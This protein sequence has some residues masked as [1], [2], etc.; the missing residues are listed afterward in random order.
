MPSQPLPGSQH[1]M[2]F[3]KSRAC[4]GW[5]C[6]TS[7]AQAGAES[8][9]AKSQF[10]AL[11]TNSAPSYPVASLCTLLGVLPGQDGETA[12]EGRNRQKWELC[13]AGHLLWILILTL[14]FYKIILEAFGVTSVAELQKTEANFSHFQ[15]PTFFPSFSATIHFNEKCTMFLLPPFFFFLQW[16]WFLSVK[17][18]HHISFNQIK[19]LASTI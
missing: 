5:L 18:N 9:P 7:V 1:R 11:I 2:N 13:R 17:I 12:S 19:L 10:T 4:H 3:D 15:K 8:K 14:G 16:K 6:R